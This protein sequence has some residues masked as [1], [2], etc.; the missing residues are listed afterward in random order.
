M[1]EGRQNDIKWLKSLPEKQLLDLFFVHVRNMWAV[2]GLYF[3]G[4]E[5]REGNEAAVEIDTEVWQIMG[6]IEMKRLLEVFEVDDNRPFDKFVTIMKSTAWWLDLEDKSLEYYPD[7]SKLILS[8]HKC[9]V[10]NNRMGKGLPEFPC[11]S[12]RLGFLESFAR[13]YNDRI[14]ATC[15]TC[16]PD[17]HGD[18]LWCQ[19]EFR[20]LE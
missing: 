15:K 17:E 4:I 12:V 1:H 9:R 19:W 2:D 16:P 13:T 5:K 14:S 7:E 18:D 20:M 10:Q 3:L 6:A 11:K 8:N